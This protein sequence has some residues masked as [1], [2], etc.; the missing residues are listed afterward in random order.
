VLAELGVDIPV[1][2]LAKRLEEVWLADASDPII[3][4]R[5]SEGLFMLQRLR[6]EA[7]RFAITHQR[8]RARKSLVDSL[9][10]EIP[11]LGQVRK[12]T[13]LKHFGSVKKLR[14]ASVEQ[15]SQVPGIGAALAATI[16]DRVAAT[17]EGL[18]INTATGEVT[19]GT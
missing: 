7:H 4:P 16:H 13:L 19:E 14:A 18:V 17:P 8:Q 3:L 11:G 2:G 15:I 10:D 6:D 1:C 9:L 12:T 5:N